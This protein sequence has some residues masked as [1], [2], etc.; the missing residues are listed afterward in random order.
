MTRDTTANIEGYRIGILLPG[1][2]G[3]GVALLPGNGVLE[4]AYIRIDLRRV[5]G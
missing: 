1:S 2:E 4:A 5:Q 3:F